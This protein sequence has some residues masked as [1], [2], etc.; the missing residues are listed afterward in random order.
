MPMS[1]Y[2]LNVHDGVN[3]SIG[4][5]GLEFDSLAAA[6]RAAALTAFELGL[7]R[8]RKGCPANH[9][10]VVEVRDEQQQRVA[11]VTSAMTIHRLAS[12]A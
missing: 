11:M 12:G 3:H 7:D 2:Y 5:E 6:E 8:V 1:R 4:E 10:M 9:E